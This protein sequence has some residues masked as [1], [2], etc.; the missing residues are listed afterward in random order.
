[1]SAIFKI[2]FRQTLCQVPL[3]STTAVRQK[4]L[5]AKVREVGA[6]G[7]APCTGTEITL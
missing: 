6:E 2:Y 5:N 1:M 7:G 3:W 4:N